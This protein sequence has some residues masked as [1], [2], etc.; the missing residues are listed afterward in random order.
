MANEKIPGLGFHHIGLMASDFEKSCAFYSALGMKELVSWGEG[1]DCNDNG[2]NDAVQHSVGNTLEVGLGE[3][4]D[5][6]ADTG[7]DRNA[8]QEVDQDRTADTADAR[9]DQLNKLRHTAEP[10]ADVRIQKEAAV[11]TADESNEEKEEAEQTVTEEAEDQTDNAE[12][13]VMILTEVL[14]GIK[15]ALDVGSD[16]GSLGKFLLD[17]INQSRDRE[18][19][20]VTVSARRLSRRSADAKDR[21]RKDQKKNKSSRLFERVFHW[22]YSFFELR[23][24]EP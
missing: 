10:R 13:D 22:F 24:M 3:D 21:D 14:H 4:E 15:C 2:D 9:D 17:I 16:D 23:F 7:N 12:C 20:G 18:A 19:L 1:N 8:E 5:S 6:V 11:A